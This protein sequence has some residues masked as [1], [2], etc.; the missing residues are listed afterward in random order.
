MG[1]HSRAARMV[2][3]INCFRCRH[4]EF[5]HPRWTVLL[6]VFLESLVQAPAETCLDH[7]ARNMRSSRRPAICQ[8]EN[9]IG[10]Q[11]HVYLVQPCNNLPDPVLP[12]TLK[13]SG[14]RQQSG[15]LCVQVITENMKLIAILLSRQFRAGNEFNTRS[16]RSNASSMA[17]FDSVMV[18]Q[19]QCRE[20]VLRS[21][22]DHLFGS[23]S[24]I[25]EDC[26]EVEISEHES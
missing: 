20:T 18:C 8:R 2:N 16:L 14:L 23:I 15:I 24:S 10:R 19:R 25:G 12:H 21:L 7:C 3:Q 17:A 5:R 13:L 9:S 22:E 1:H 11:R 26:V 6:E 4:F